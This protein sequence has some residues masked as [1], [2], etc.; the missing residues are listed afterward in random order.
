MVAR[1]RLMPRQIWAG[2]RRPKPTVLERI[3]VESSPVFAAGDLTFERFTVVTGRHA[4]GKSWLL[5]VIGSVIPRGDLLIPMGPPLEPGALKFSG[6]GELGGVYRVLARQS[7]VPTSWSANLDRETPSTANSQIEGQLDLDGCAASY[8]HEPEQVSI[9]FDPV[10][11]FFDYN[12][13]ISGWAPNLDAPTPVSA[14]VIRAIEAITGRRFE[15]LFWYQHDLY[16]DVVGPYAVGVANGQEITSHGMS[17]GEL[18]V[19]YLLWLLD[20][21]DEK[22]LLLI[23]EPETFL[24]PRGHVPLLL[25][26][27]RLARDRG[28]QVVLA[29]HSTEMISATPPEMLRVLVP[30][31]DGRVRVHRTTSARTALRALGY[32]QPVSNL[33]LVED[34]S[35]VQVL[36]ALLRHVDQPLAD[37]SDIIRSGGKN[38]ALNAANVIAQAARV[39]SAVV[40]DGNERGKP[41]VD[42][43]EVEPLFLPGN[44]NPED[45]LLTAAMEHAP[46]LAAN[47]QCSVDAIDAALDET[48][49]ARHQYVFARLAESL[50][51]TQSTIVDHIVA[52][53]LAD[54]DVRSEADELV[55]QLRKSAQ[56]PPVP[57]QS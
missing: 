42:F 57:L 36:S 49:G 27:A 9:Y 16:D 35:A 31:G 26:V 44:E 39:T 21:L 25:E 54:P 6:K 12:E 24:A 33:I 18:W 50:G 43:P 52:V 55:A 2:L 48:V 11:A 22:W 40:L 1:D 8:G 51:V 28:V 3:R 15:E 34:Q 5:R 4:A 45:S 7:G 29:T 10:R 17:R 37:V 53:W 46:T 30:T 47:L 38:Q 23:D 32:Q 41:L 19:H 56:L 14:N 13:I 20:S